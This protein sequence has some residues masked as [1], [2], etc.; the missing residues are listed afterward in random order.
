MLKTP[1]RRKQETTDRKVND[2][3]TRLIQRG[4]MKEAAVLSSMKKFNVARSTVYK[5]NK[6]VQARQLV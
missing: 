6:R 4:A 2:Y 3:Y 5:I 1:A